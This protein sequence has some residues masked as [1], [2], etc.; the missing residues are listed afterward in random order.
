MPDMIHTHSQ[1]PSLKRNPNDAIMLDELVLQSATHHNKLKVRF[2]NYRARLNS[3]SK[4]F[5][6]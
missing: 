2:R 4:R 1:L 5:F 3:W 6:A